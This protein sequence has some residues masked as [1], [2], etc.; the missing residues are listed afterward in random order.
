MRWSRCSAN[1]AVAGDEVGCG[2]SDKP[3]RPYTLNFY[4]DTLLGFL[5]ALHVGAVDV[6]GGSLGGNLVL[7]LGAREPDRFA[8]LAA[9]APAGVWDPARISAALLRVLGG[10]VLFWPMLRIQSRYWYAPTWPASRGAQRHFPLLSGRRPRVHSQLHWDI[11]IDQMQQS[12][13]PLAKK[14]AQPV[15]LGWGDKDNGLYAP[16]CAA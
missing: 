10:R 6:A 12:L 1:I 4:E 8:H 3:D 16:A 9:W 7:R 2:F 5:D 13:F 11:A 15:F 14:I